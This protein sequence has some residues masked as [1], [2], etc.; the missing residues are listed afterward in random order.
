MCPAPQIQKEKSGVKADGHIWRELRRNK[1]PDRWIPPQYRDSIIH[2]TRKGPLGRLV[3]KRLTGVVPNSAAKLVKQF[4]ENTGGREDIIEKLEAVQDQLPKDQLALLELLK[5][6]NPTKSLARLMAE[7]KV[8][9]TKTMDFYARG[10]VH[11]GK[12]QAAIIAHRNLPGIVKDLVRHAIDEEEVCQVCVGSGLVKKG[13]GKLKD[14]EKCP[15]CR[16][17]GRKWTSSDYKEF[18]TT[19]LLEATKVIASKGEGVT[20]NVQTNVKVAGGGSFMEKVVEASDKVLYGQD[21]IE[22]EFVQTPEPLALV[23]EKVPE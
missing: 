1:V 21:V 19:K 9:P 15:Q 11:L 3:V 18:A 13:S 4:E 16:G 22:A 5:T 7:I 6:A 12:V 2:K 10:A 17:K 14:D 8:E 23:P 20:V